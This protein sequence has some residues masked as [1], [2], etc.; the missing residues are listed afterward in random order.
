VNPGS[1]LLALKEV[2]GVEGAL[3][4]DPDGALLEHSLPT[5]FPDESVAVVAQRMAPLFE[6]IREHVDKVDELILN[7]EG[8]TLLLRRVAF[9]YLALLANTRSSI[10]PIRMA[11]TMVGKRLADP[12]AGANTPQPTSVA[13]VR[14]GSSVRTGGVK[15]VASANK[16]GGA[17]KTGGVPTSVKT[18]GV[19][20]AVKKPTKKSDI[21]GD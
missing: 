19:K 6:T 20:P 9:G 7:F 10:E 4:G 5:F 11:A 3:W 15:S 13:S 18:G 1:K 8:Y 21:W 2:P 12:S 14:S 16:T 17:Q